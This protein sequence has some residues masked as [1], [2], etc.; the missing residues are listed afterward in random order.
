[1]NMHSGVFPSVAD[2]LLSKT[3]ISTHQTLS[4]RRPEQRMCSISF[5]FFCV[6]NHV[7]THIMTQILL[8]HSK[9]EPCSHYAKWAYKPSIGV[10]FY[11]NTTNCNSYIT[12][13]CHKFTN[14]KY[15]PQMQYMPITSC[16]TLRQLC[17]YIYLI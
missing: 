12:H 10:H 8:L 16:A 17:Q 9:Y 6:S 2:N 11:K 14:K 4:P 1:M 15:A 3:I 7:C 5:A 13:Y